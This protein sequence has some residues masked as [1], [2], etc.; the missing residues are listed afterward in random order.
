MSTIFLRFTDEPAY[1]A[2]IAPFLDPEGGITIPNWD[3][4]GVITRGGEWDIDGNVIVEPEV[5]DGYHVNAL[6]VP[7]G[8]EAYV[9]ERPNLPH[10]VFATK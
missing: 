3:V 7:T 1:Q 10:R 6:E 8:L 2:A 4:V 9:I 5:L